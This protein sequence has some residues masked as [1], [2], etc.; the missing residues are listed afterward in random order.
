[1]TATEFNSVAVILLLYPI[2]AFA[3]LWRR[4]VL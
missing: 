1:M 4:F 2:K 3:Y